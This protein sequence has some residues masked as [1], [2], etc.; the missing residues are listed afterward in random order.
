MEKGKKERKKGKERKEEKGRDTDTIHSTHLVITMAAF[1]SFYEFLI[2]ISVVGENHPRR[3]Y[4][5]QR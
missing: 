3:E 2:L 5:D 1:L 4:R